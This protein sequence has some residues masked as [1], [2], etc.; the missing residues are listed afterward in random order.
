MMWFKR[1]PKPSAGDKSENGVVSKL[2]RKKAVLLKPSQQSVDREPSTDSD[3]ERRR[4]SDI[5]DMKVS[6]GM[7]VAV[8]TTGRIEDSLR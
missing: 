6:L 2:K 1:D 8:M 4:Y 5:L 7:G 3:K